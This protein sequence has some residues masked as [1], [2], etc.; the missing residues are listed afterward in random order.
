LIGSSKG[1][2]QSLA[3]LTLRNR[4][5]DLGGEATTEDAVE[6]VLSNL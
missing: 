6:A 2:P 5:L 1:R 4:T 3:L